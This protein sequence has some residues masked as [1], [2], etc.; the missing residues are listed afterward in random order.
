MAL[1]V[2]FIKVNDKNVKVAKHSII[3]PKADTQI[4]T[5]CFPVLTTPKPIIFYYS[6]FIRKFVVFAFIAT[7]TAIQIL[8]CII[9]MV[10]INWNFY[11][12]AT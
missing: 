5:A 1:F 9:V 4:F 6:F 10:D 2:K 7:F 8:N 3:Q 12:F 11:F